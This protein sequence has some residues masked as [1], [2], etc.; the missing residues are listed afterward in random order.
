[1]IKSNDKITNG[2]MLAIVINTIIGVG[3]LSLPRVLAEELKTDGWILL[4]T[5]GVIVIG[6]VV[7]ITMLVK[8]YPNKTVIEFSREII[9]TPISV[10]YSAIYI[11]YILVFVAFV[12]RIFGEIVKMYLLPQTPI[13]IIII[14]MLLVSTYLA[15]AGVEAI[16]RFS[17]L[18]TPLVILPVLL[19]GVILIPDMDFT[20]VFPVFQFE[21]IDLVKALPD[22]VFSFVGFEIILLLTAFI[23]KPEKSLKCNLGAIIAVMVIYIYVFFITLLVFG[24]KELTHLLWPSISLMETIEFPGAFLENIQGIVMAQWVI[25]VF[26]TLTPLL[27]GAALI[28]SKTLKAKEHNY[29]VLPLI[30][31]IFILALIPDNLPQSYDYITKAGYY[32]GGF[33]LIVIPVTLYIGSLLRKNKR[34]GAS[35]NG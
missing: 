35:K 2:Q 33:V 25:V 30:P 26:T 16:G 18:I 10:I 11:A 3:I 20:N 15:R 7:I 21:I 27:Y 19:I 24:Q 1:M 32:L 34:K 23:D 17:V 28:I 29:Y 5:S 8:K 12:V 6:L 4:V 31:I 13:E 14:S 9:N 22:T